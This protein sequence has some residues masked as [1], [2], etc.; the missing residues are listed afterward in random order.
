MIIRQ[1]EEGNDVRPGT[2]Q[3]AEELRMTYFWT[4]FNVLTMGLVDAAKE[5]SVHHEEEELREEERSLERNIE[6]LESA[7]TCLLTMREAAYAFVKEDAKSGPKWSLRTKETKDSKEQLADIGLFFHCYPHCSVNSLH[8]H[9][10]DLSATGPTYDACKHKNLRLDM[11]LE[12]LEKE[13]NAL[14]PTK[15]ASTPR[16]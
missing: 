16:R 9:I 7:R 14:E 4:W 5:D 12:A 8:L 10:V 3:S 13:I 6:T 2:G 1:P 11:V 15:N